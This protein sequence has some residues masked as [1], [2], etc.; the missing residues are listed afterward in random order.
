MDMTKLADVMLRN[1]GHTGPE[2]GMCVMEAVAFLANEEFGDHPM[3]ACPVVGAFLRKFND[4]LPTDELRTELLMPLVSKLVGSKSTPEVDAKRRWIMVDWTVRVCAPLWIDLAGM[5][6]EAKQLRDLPEVTKETYSTAV[7]TTRNVRTAAYAAY[8]AYA[9]SADASASAYA[10]AYAA[11]A[12]YAASAYAAYAAADYAADYAAY[13]AD[14][15]AYA[16]DAYAADY[17]AA[18]PML[19]QTAVVARKS[20]IEMI[21]KCLAVTE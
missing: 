12:A 4:R 6:A 1:G 3:C 14:Y 10:A 17:A 21:E 8:A 16:A 15:A 5:S 20:A 19:A 2:Q 7:A 13:A 11:Y 9:A 18:G